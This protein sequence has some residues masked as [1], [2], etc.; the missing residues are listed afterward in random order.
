LD[1]CTSPPHPI[2]L[3]SMVMRSSVNSIKNYSS[4]S[5]HH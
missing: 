4:N 3:S 5:F 1:V 2:H